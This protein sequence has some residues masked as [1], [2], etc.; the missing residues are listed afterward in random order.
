MKTSDLGQA[1]RNARA[2]P[3]GDLGAQ[4]WKAFTV[5][6]VPAPKPVGPRTPKSA[7]AWAR[8]KAWK[9]LIGYTANR[10]YPRPLKDPVALSCL[11]YL[12]PTIEIY[13]LAGQALR[14][15]IQGKTVPTGKPDLKNLV[16]AVEDSLTGIAW[17][18]DAQVVTYGSMEKRWEVANMPRAFVVIE[19]LPDGLAGLRQYTGYPLNRYLETEQN[20]G[21]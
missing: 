10:Y 12:P 6:G 13:G 21:D 15:V 7:D 5:N 20:L 8:Y 2:A 11:F 3:K 18:D 1:S 16:A 9:E 14:Q 19:A 4:S 17:H